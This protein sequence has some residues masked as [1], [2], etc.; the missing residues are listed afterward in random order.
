MHICACTH[1]LPVPVPVLVHVRL[2]VAWVGGSM[3]LSVHLRGSVVL[4]YIC[5]CIVDEIFS[6]H[7]VPLQ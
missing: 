2:H 5:A 4:C 1:A 7:I 3:L 6:S